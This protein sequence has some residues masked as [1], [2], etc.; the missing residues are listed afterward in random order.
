MSILFKIADMEQSHKY[1]H[2]VYYNP[3]DDSISTY[4]KVIEQSQIIDWNCAICNDE[5]Q[6]QEGEFSMSNFVCNKCKDAHN[7]DN[8]RI[9]PRIV[10]S[11]HEFHKYCRK[12]LMKEQRKFLQY[13]KYFETGYKR[14]RI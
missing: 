10:D 8:N 4:E 5:I 14:G 13:I 12:R 7:S 6:S 2:K 3:Y 1:K 9:D 11:S